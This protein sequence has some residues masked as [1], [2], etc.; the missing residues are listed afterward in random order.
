MKKSSLQ[1]VLM[2][3]ISLS[4]VHLETIKFSSNFKFPDH[5][6]SSLQSTWMQ[7][8]QQKDS[9]VKNVFCM[10]EVPINQTNSLGNY[11]QGSN[12]QVKGTD[13]RVSGQNNTMIGRNNTMFGDLN[14]LFGLDNTVLGS[15]N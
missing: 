3:A 13:N 10:P 7:A 8:K 1:I 9:Q 5:L 2:I 12:N 6:F 15:K 14:K 4:L 11:L